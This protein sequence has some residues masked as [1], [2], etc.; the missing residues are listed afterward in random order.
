MIDAQ[1]TP[2]AAARNTTWYPSTCCCSGFAT[3]SVTD[4]VTAE[5]NR[6]VKTAVP[7]DPPIC[8]VPV[9]AAPATPASRGSMPES[10]TFCMGTNTNASPMPRRIW[11]GS[12]CTTYAPSTVIRLNHSSPAAARSGPIVMRTRGPTFGRSRATCGAVS[13]MV[14]AIGSDARPEISGDMPS[15][16]WKCSVR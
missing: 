6:A 11:P 5:A 4:A 10:A 2:I 16:I 15:T 13:M 12:T 8:C 3:P 1:A 7:M 9:S 14:A